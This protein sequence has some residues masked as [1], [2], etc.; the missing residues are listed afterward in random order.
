MTKKYVFW[1]L[2]FLTALLSQI[3]L[4]SRPQNMCCKCTRLKRRDFD[5]KK[6]GSQEEIVSKT[7]I[8]ASICLFSFFHIPIQITKIE[9]EQY[10]LKKG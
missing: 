1:V 10:K 3:A 7:T 5:S 9:F 8:P 4:L 6:L 2:L